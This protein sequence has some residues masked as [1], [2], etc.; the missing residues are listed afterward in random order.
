[1]NMLSDT[2]RDTISELKT[3]NNELLIDIEKKDKIEQQRGE[4]ISNVSHELKTPLALISGYCE[5]LKECV[6]D[7]AESRDYYCDVIIDETA[8][9]NRMVQKLLT[10]NNLEF[11][12]QKIELDR[13][14]LSELIDSVVMSNMLLAEKKGATI[15]KDYDANIYAWADA[16]EIE[17]VVTN[18]ISNAIN[19]VSGDMKIRI[20]IS[21]EGEV[22]R[23][24]IF[25]SG[26]HIP[27][28]DLTKIW[29]KFYKVDK[30][31]TREYGGSGIGLSIVKA[32]MESHHHKCGCENVDSGVVFWFELDKN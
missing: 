6:N 18:Y 9:M 21:S 20:N 24:N 29:D 32:I 30:A 17:E 11:G 4:F 5:G 25:N 15:E 16:F 28:D 31:R 10:L 27:D 13:F 2:L 1:M 22:L 3:A 26:K 12:G 23:V 7:D 8:K 19:H 14:C